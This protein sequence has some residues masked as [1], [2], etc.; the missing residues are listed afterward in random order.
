M[1]AK[2]CE[3]IPQGKLS[4]AT[5]DDLP[6]ELLLLIYPLLPLKALIAARG[7]CRRWRSLV[8]EA[9][10]DPARKQ[11]L[12]LYLQA[13]ETPVFL[14]TRPQIVPHLVHFNRQEY[15]DY[16]IQ[17][18]TAP[19]DFKIW[20]LEWPGKATIEW[21]WPGLD[22]I[23]YEMEVHGLRKLVNNGLAY[24]PPYVKSVTYHKRKSDIARSHTIMHATTYLPAGIDLPATNEISWSDDEEMMVSVE[25]TT[26]CLRKSHVEGEPSL[27]LALEG[28]RGAEYMA[29]VV[30][31]SGPSLG[32]QSIVAR[33]WPE[34][35]QMELQSAQDRWEQAGNIR[36]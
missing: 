1:I 21:L 9:D 36:A 26:L 34:F 11:L 7:V 10:L 18:S 13:I 20:L 4:R 6:N 2:E 29:G 24:D 25:I 8:T 27:W 3:H 22:V 32:M 16:L 5:G 31:L 23:T 30:Y 19:E 17:H 14:A 33:S 28:R 12:E 15:L 35:L